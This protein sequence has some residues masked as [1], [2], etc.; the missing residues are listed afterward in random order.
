[1]KNKEIV[2]KNLTRISLIV[3]I[4]PFVFLLGFVFYHYHADIPVEVLKERLAQAPSEFMQLDDMEVHYRDEGEG[5]PLVLIHGTASSLHTWDGWATA[6]QDSFRVIRLDLP[7]YGLTGPNKDHQYNLEYY[8]DFLHRFLKRLQIDSCHIAGNSLG[9]A[10]V[11]AYTLKHPESVG[12]MVLVNASGPFQR[13]KGS[14]TALN[15]ASTPIVNKIARYVT[16]K[17]LVEKSLNEVYGN[18]EKVSEELVN[19]YFALLLRE[20]NRDALVNRRRSKK[21]RQDW[22]LKEINAPTMIMWG[23]K[24]TWIPVAMADSFKQVIP[25][26]QLKIYPNAGHIPMEEIPLV[27]SK[28]IR[29]FLEKN[30]LK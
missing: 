17:F 7:A 14:R 6:L 1:M 29:A 19:R 24:D 2:N 21:T 25:H 30:P 22:N 26:A 10:V 5:F 18:N 9:G 11:W 15:L 20:G 4:F 12:K 23:K 3:F 27:S 13:K 16:P 8:A 28:D